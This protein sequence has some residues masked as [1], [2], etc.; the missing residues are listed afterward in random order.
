MPLTA[1]ERDKLLLILALLRSDKVGEV[2]A[3]AAAV[4][5]LLQAAGLTWDDVLSPAAWEPPPEPPPDP[6]IERAAAVARARSRSWT[7]GLSDDEVD[8]A[9]GFCD[10]AEPSPAQ[11]RQMDVIMAKVKADAV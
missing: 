1:P 5:R 6:A 9:V 7:R 11:Q 3:A 10:L 4:L 2:N 8:F